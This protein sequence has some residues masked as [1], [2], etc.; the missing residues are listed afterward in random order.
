ML[1]GYRVGSGL[2]LGL[3]IRLLARSKA[4]SICERA[5]LCQGPGQ[6]NKSIYKTRQ[7]KTRQVV[8]SE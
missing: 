4:E 1:D 2:Q 6:N 7:D 5:Q 3:K 8:R